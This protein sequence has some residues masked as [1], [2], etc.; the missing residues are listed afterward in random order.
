[1]AIPVLQDISE[2]LVTSQIVKDAIMLGKE[3]SIVHALTA[4][5]ISGAQAVVKKETTTV[6]NLLPYAVDTDP[7]AVRTDLQEIDGMEKTIRLDS[8]VLET[9]HIRIPFIIPNVQLATAISGVDIEGAVAR[10]AQ[11]NIKGRLD[12]DL[13]ESLTIGAF[14]GLPATAQDQMKYNAKPSYY[15]LST[16]IANYTYA[17]YTAHANVQAIVQAIPNVAG[18]GGFSLNA[19]RKMVR[20]AEGCEYS[21]SEQ[22]LQSPDLFMGGNTYSKGYILLL[23]P[24]AWTQ[25]ENDPNFLQLYLTRGVVQSGAPQVLTGESY[26]GMAE[27]IHIFVSNQMRFAERAKNDGTKVTWNLLLGSQALHWHTL[28]GIRVLTN[29]ESEISMDEKLRLKVSTMYGMK[30]GQI[31]SIL[32]KAERFDYG[33][34]HNFSATA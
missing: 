2:Q 22:S 10:M 23:H 12:R 32:G 31:Q 24:L 9:R 25:L 4:G 1:M 18:G 33:V 17:A 20:I 6:R 28:E 26:K 8:D 34:V 15:R 13:I 3:S 27:G 16:A 5:Q 7:Y 11:I 19:L 29:S 30:S 14:T 21:D